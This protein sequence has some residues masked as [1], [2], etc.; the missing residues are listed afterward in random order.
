MIE[1]DMEDLIA[2]HPDDFFPDRGFE[3]RGRQQSL[4]GVGRRFDLLFEDR[5]R[6]KILMELKAVPAKYEVATQLAAYKDELQNRGET[7][8]LMWLV[9]PHI[10]QSVREFLD[11]IGIEYSEIHVP[12]FRRV[13]ERHGEPIH[14]EA[15][16]QD[17]AAP[18]FEESAPAAFGSNRRRIGTRPQVDIG[19]RVTSH[20]AL[21]WTAQGYDLVLSN[22]QQFDGATFAALVDAFAKAVPSGRNASLVRELQRWAP[23]VSC[24]RWLHQSNAPLLRWVTT[25]S[26]K[27]SVPHAHAI[28]KYLFGEPVPTWYVWNQSRRCY[29]FDHDAW[30]VWFESLN[31]RR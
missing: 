13:A 10:P 2:N 3:L 4:A 24:S 1:R 27:S 21:N 23:N 30:T 29:E 22:P 17:L 8:I 6:T 12:E 28:W 16:R 9:A 31:E 15:P 18:R 14:S 26:Y 7:H 20:S 25:S 5:F 19:P 11:R